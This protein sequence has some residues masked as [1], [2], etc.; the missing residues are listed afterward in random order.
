MFA[1]NRYTHLR[2]VSR[3]VAKQNVSKSDIVDIFDDSIDLNMIVV[4]VAA[5][6]CC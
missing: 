2:V 1:N 5:D 6:C 3:L 4:V